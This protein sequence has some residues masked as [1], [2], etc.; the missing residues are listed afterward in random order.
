MIELLALAAAFL[1]GLGAR[2]IGLPP[3]V[4][5]LVCG[6]ALHPLGMNTTTGIEMFAEMGVSLLLF[7]IGLKLR[8]RNLLMPQVWGVASLH[9]LL[10]VVLLFL[11]M[12]GLGVVGLS[13][14]SDLSTPAIAL[15]AFALSFS[16]TIFAVKVLEDSGEMS[17]LHG[18]I[19]IG[20]LVVQDIV[21]VV[22]LAVSAGKVPST[23]AFALLLLIPARP[24]LRWLLAHAG[25]GELQVLFGLS[26]A[27][28][29][30][31][32][33]ELT[34]VK[35]DLGALILGALLAGNARA[36]ELS[37]HLLAFKDLFLVG[38]FL[39]IGLA[40]GVSIQTFGI[41][42][43]LIAFLPLKS[44]LFFR[45]FTASRLRSRSSFLTSLSLANYSEFGLIVGTVAVGAGWVP[46]EWLTIMALAL[47]VS[48]IL[49]APL[50]TRAH[51]LYERC[52]ERLSRFEG[53][54]RI[55]E[56]ARIQPGAATALVLGMGRVGAGA[57]DNLRERMGDMV[58]GIDQ[59]AEAVER[60]RRAGRN[61]ALGSSFDPE[62]WR[63]VCMDFGKVRL[64]MLAMLGEDENLEAARQLR[65]IGYGGP[66]AAIVH[67]PD[68][69]DEL[70]AAGVDHVVD[71]Y[72][73]AGAGF[74]EDV[75]GELGD[76]LLQGC[77]GQA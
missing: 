10:T 12:S 38:F 44:L 5:Y 36:S 20:V 22:F 67:Y 41:A 6:F 68:E 50:N 71:L 1:F 28:G 65:G 75:R 49:S 21:A 25:H 76:V 26:M 3:L 62:F 70:R 74:A 15:V 33:F 69:A 39:T 57:Y 40:G 34:G 43:L 52:S 37:D 46:T 73:G 8:L 45:L 2:R 77:T 55:S 11:L 72:E 9:M 13:V 4:G 53:S 32:V 47:A 48:F 18:R 16:S 42:L 7:T 56:E 24:L 35:G 23:W 29:G 27:L 19:A 14:F 58:L 54:V 63:R 30:A 51:R 61:V 17:A 60:H 64:V 59:D 66:L 31:Q